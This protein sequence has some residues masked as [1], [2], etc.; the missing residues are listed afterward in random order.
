MKVTAL[1]AGRWCIAL[2]AVLSFYC[3]AP[4]TAAPL[5][6]AETKDEDVLKTMD[7]TR[8][9]YQ[10]IRYERSKRFRG[11]RRIFNGK[12]GKGGPPP[13]PPPAVC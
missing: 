4:C 13:G 2:A 11:K 8:S 1:T 6:S 9:K 12:P 3:A 7:Q 5:I 10:V